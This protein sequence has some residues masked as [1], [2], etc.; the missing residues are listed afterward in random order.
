M[1][2]SLIN[3]SEILELVNKSCLYF[4][5]NRESRCEGIVI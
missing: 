5:S 2:H 4:V 1:K 3:S